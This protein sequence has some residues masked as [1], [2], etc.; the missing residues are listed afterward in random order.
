VS[1]YTI[2][3]ILSDRNP[4]RQLFHLFSSDSIVKV[5]KKKNSPIIKVS[6][7]FELIFWGKL[8]KKDRIKE[9]HREFAKMVTENGS[10]IYC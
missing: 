7:N 9:L 4:V 10:Q 6:F 3:S 8:K 2:K 1:L 5:E